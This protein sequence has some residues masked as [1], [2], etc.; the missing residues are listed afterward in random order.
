MRPLSA[1][2]ELLG[3]RCCNA[4]GML[5]CALSPASLWRIA[6]RAWKSATPELSAVHSASGDVTLCGQKDKVGV[7]GLKLLAGLC[8]S[9]PSSRS[10]TCASSRVC[11]K[12]VIVATGK[13]DGQQVSGLYARRQR[14]HG[15]HRLEPAG[16]SYEKCNLDKTRARFE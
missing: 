6:S 2:D 5:H 10:G 9:L 1:T 4:C 3:C 8:V 13:P 15:P 16:S 11:R 14:Q 12:V 7:R